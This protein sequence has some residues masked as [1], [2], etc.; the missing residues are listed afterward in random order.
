[1]AIVPINNEDW[2]FETNC[3]VCEP[4]NE[5]GL[6]VAFFHD[7][8]EE[9]V[10]AE[11]EL[12]NDYSG[13]PTLVHGGVTL[14]IADEAMAWACIACGHQW[15]VTSETSTSFLGALYI[16]KRYRVEARVVAADDTSMSTTA[17]ISDMESRVRVR[18]QARFSTLG[19]AQAGRL[20][21]AAE[22]TIANSYLRATA[23][24]AQ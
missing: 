24:P 18:S 16:G 22:G 12:S 13:A 14:A 20:T 3:Y 21:G 4:K 6:R 1:M 5:R 19:P 17:V 2:G 23:P 9:L 11:F 10:F 8:V 15:A 7:T